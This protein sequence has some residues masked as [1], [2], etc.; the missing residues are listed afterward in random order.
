MTFLELTDGS[1][2]SIH[3]WQMWLRL[4]DMSANFTVLSAKVPVDLLPG[5]I[6][7]HDVWYAITLVKQQ[8]RLMRLLLC[9]HWESTSPS[10]GSTEHL[11]ILVLAT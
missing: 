11:C 9:T 5:A 6:H 4:L 1:F 10:L 8:K 2:G 3:P 7:Y